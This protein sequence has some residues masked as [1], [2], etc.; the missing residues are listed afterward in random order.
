MSIQKIFEEK[1]E[2]FFRKI[3]EKITLQESKKKEY[4]NI[5][6]WRSFYE[7]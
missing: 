2:V 6:R 1:G 3:E 5:S 7:P 4:S